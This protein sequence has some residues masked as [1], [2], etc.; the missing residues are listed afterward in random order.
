M[1]KNNRFWVFGLL[2]LAFLMHSPQNSAEQVGEMTFGSD[3]APLTVIEYSSLTC[4]HCAEF[5]EKVFPQIQ[6]NYIKT[7]KVHFII[8]PYP[9]DGVALKAN[10]IVASQPPLGQYALYSKLMANQGIWALSSDPVKSI[11]DISGIP[12]KK[13]EQFAND[14]KI[15]N[16]LIEG[17]LIADKDV[18]I[19]AT[20][21]FIIN[22][23]K[24]PYAI[25]Y[26][27]FQKAVGGV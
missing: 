25:T 21:L 27:Q 8:R 1:A 7:G 9:I 17:R 14:E 2:F 16:G 13:C 20:P 18:Q 23:R 5:H 24:F 12:L 19:E 10:A 22:G 15:Q 26:D 4:G 11:A 6:E 3:D